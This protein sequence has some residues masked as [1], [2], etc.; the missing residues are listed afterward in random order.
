MKDKMLILFLI[1]S[2]SGTAQNELNSSEQ[3]N[4]SATEI[5]QNTIDEKFYI[6][7][8]NIPI[9]NDL[10]FNSLENCI[11]FI[12]SLHDVNCLD[13]YK[14]SEVIEFESGIVNTFKTDS[15]LYVVLKMGRVYEFN[16]ADKSIRKILEIKNIQTIQDTGLLSLAINDQ[17]DEFAISYINKDFELI[18]DKYTYDDDISDHDFANQIFSQQMNKPYTHLGGNLIWSQYFNTFLI[19]VGDNQEANEFS[20]INPAPLDTTNQL[21]KILALENVEIDVPLIFTQDKD[22]K[23]SNIVVY[24]LRSPWQFFEHNGYL[25]VFDVGLSIHE[26]M[27]IS[28]LSSNAVSYGWPIFEGGS[29][30]EIIDEIKDYS[31]EITYNLGDSNLNSED[32]LRKLESEAVS[33]NFFYSHYPTESD[34]RGAI[35]GGDVILGNNK[36]YTLNFVSADITT[37]ELFLY[38]ITDGSLKIVPPPS[39]DRATITNI[40]AMNNNIS[41]LVVGT[42]EGKLIFIDLPQF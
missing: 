14:V 21:G 5:I 38:D 40:R 13:S 9:L 1:I 28:K 39:S 3:V 23:L 31:I 25:A 19:S 11:D 20:R 27:T 8:K 34:Y 42:Y 29:K 2:C 16:F 15:S 22:A 6:N 30:A 41:D 7:E 12:G 33:P 35:I 24:G 26:E 37:N 4:D 10:H 36:N 32:S 17:G 18:V